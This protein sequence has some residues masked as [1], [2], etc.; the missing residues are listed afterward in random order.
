M[1]IAKQIIACFSVNSC[2]IGLNGNLKA[3]RVEKHS[4]RRY[5]YIDVKVRLYIVHYPGE[6]NSGLGYVMY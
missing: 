2:S 5:Y 3:V 1:L 4:E 6:I